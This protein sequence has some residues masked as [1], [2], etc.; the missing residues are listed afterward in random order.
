MAVSLTLEARSHLPPAASLSL[1]L[2]PI[3]GRKGR[4]GLAGNS[5]LVAFLAFQALIGVD[6]IYVF[7]GV[8]DDDHDDHHGHYDHDDD[9]RT[10]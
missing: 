9:R 2:G 4:G 10:R 7:D 5:E 1:C 6:R 3:F 8:R